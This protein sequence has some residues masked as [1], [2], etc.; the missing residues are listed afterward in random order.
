MDGFYE[1]NLECLSIYFN[2]LKNA[3]ICA[4]IVIIQSNAQVAGIQ[5]FWGIVHVNALK[6]SISMDNSA[7]PVKL[8]QDYYN[9][10][11]I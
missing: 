11:V 6:I 5:W 8:N 2:I 3:L 10:F 4:K 9:P 1:K 7:F